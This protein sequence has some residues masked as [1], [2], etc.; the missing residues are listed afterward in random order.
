VLYPEL[1]ILTRVVLR[2]VTLALTKVEEVYEYSD[3]KLKWQAEVKHYRDLLLTVPLCQDGCHY[4]VKLK[5][6]DQRVVMSETWPVIQIS[7]KKRY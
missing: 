4:L 1:F 2:Q 3:K 7:A 6:R 5:N